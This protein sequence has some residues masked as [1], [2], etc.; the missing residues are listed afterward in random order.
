MGSTSLKK[1]ADTFLYDMGLLEKLRSYGEPHVIGS[2]LTDTMA[3]N[4][5][6]ID[7]VNDKMSLEKLH[8]LTAYILE[9]FKPCWY[10]AKQ[11]IT[12]DGKTVWFHGFETMITG[13]LWNFDLW[14]FDTE[15]IQATEA[16]AI[17]V[18]DA[19]GQK[20]DRRKVIVNLK[21]ELIEK[22][23]YPNIYTSASVYDAVIKH[24][25]VSAELFVDLQ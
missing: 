16:Y 5:V 22:G 25:V 12:E 19:I 3:W 4:D 17:Y 7:I 1:K 20:P 21:K 13:E 9:S 2:Y 10:E 18:L 14:F 8:E 15:T 11:E 24:N 23:L 6:D